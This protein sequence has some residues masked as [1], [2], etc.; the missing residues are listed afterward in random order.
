MQP[1]KQMLEQQRRGPSQAY[2]LT[3]KGEQRRF[4]I[5]TQ[6]EPSHPPTSS[7]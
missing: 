4:A 2:Y 5:Q 3:E 6:T 1:A 7:T